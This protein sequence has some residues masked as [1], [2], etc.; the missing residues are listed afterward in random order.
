MG[1]I[2]EVTIRPVQV[3]DAAAIN[4]V[5]RQPS[6]LE[7]TFALPGESL[8]ATQGFLAGFS[9]DDHGLVAEVDG[10][11]VGMAGLHRKPGKRSHSA[12]IGMMVRDQFQ[13]RGLGRRLLERLLDIADNQLGLTRVELEVMAD[14]VRAIKL[15]EAS[16]FEHEGRKRKAIKRRQSHVDLL[17]MSR[18]R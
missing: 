4:E 15:Y 9:A 12:E 1:S 17:V 16:G 3:A 11:V 13:G 10:R 14:N 5:R 7:F 6:V 8:E 2:P 18:L